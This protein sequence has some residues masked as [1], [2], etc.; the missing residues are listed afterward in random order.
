MVRNEGHLC[1]LGRIHPS[2][3]VDQDRSA[4]LRE[5]S[6]NK[7]HGDV[8]A[9]CGTWTATLDLA[10]L[11]TILVV[12]CG[13]LTRRST[14]RDEADTLDGSTITDLTKN[15]VSTDETTLTATTLGDGPVEG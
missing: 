5:L 15:V 11:A 12:D 10:D 7:A 9:D 4:R 6:F 1:D 14:G 8:L 13:T 2:T 3:D